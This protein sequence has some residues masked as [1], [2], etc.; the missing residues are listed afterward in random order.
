MAIKSSQLALLARIDQV[1]DPADL[2]RLGHMLNNL[3]VPDIAHHIESAPPR[4]RR[5]LWELLDEE[6]E[7]EV[8]GELSEQVRQEFLDEMDSTE[9]AAL[10]EGMDPDDIA[11]ILNQLPDQVIPEVLRAMDEQDRQRV[12][13]VLSFAEDTAGGLMNTDTITVRPDRKSVV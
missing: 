10:F 3:A 12:E 11:D 13:K 5:I 2:N 7:G 4:A 9:L 1:I 6:F 8:L